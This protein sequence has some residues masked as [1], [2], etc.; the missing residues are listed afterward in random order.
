MDIRLVAGHLL[1][2]SV[3]A[4]MEKEEKKWHFTTRV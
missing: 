1:K 2:S 3:L 4:F